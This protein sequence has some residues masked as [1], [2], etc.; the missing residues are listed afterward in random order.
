MVFCQLL[1]WVGGWWVEGKSL[2]RKRMRLM[3]H[4]RCERS[5]PSETEMEVGTGVESTVVCYVAVMT[6][7]LHLSHH[8]NIL[9]FFTSTVMYREVYGAGHIIMS[10]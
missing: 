1:G 10:S 2:P 8:C 4:C 6:S 9:H 7:S 3:P 5:I